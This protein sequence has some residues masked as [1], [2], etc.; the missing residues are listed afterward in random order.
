MFASLANVLGQTE[1]MP[2]PTP[3]IFK[4]YKLYDVE[5]K[6]GLMQVCILVCYCLDVHIFSADICIKDYYFVNFVHVL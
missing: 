1:N 6:Y 3:S 5:I 2:V 4:D